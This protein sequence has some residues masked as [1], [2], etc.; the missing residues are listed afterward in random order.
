M[1]GS[2]KY[3]QVLK[4]DV[5]KHWFDLVK[6]FIVDKEIKKYNIYGMDESSFSLQTKGGRRLLGDG[7][8]KVSIN[9]AGLIERMLR[10]LSPSALMARH[11]HRLSYSKVRILWLNGGKI[12]FQM[13]REYSDVFFS[14]NY[15]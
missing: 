13:H 3:S 5:V 14:I 10:P 4:P 1:W 2:V 8:P 9:R 6:E 12:M 11:S 7:Q 15:L